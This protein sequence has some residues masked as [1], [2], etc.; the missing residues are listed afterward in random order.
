MNADL[1]SVL[2]D[3][4]NSSQSP[5]IVPHRHPDGDAL[6]SALAIF[7]SLQQA[8][9]APHVVVPTSIPKMLHWMPGVEQAIVAP[10]HPDIAQ[11]AIDKADLLVFVDFGDLRRLD[12]LVETVQQST[13]PIVLIDHHP[14]PKITAEYMW[15]DPHAPATALLIYRL[16]QKGQ[17]RISSTIAQ[18]LLTGIITDTGRFNYSLSPE[19]FTTTADLIA[20]G[21][22]LETIIQRIFYRFSENQLRFWGHT[23]SEQMEI[24]HP[25]PIALM[26]VSHKDFI[27]WK[28]TEDDLEGLVNFPLQ[29]KDIFISI[30]IRETPEEVKL[31]FRSRGPYPV[32]RWASEYFQ[33]GGHFHAA[34]AR[35][36]QPLKQ[37]IAQVK[38]SLPHFWKS[39]HDTAHHQT[40]NS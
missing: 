1:A 9:G 40:T 39:I 5:T 11:Q 27:Q 19:V 38:A 20:H 32:N 24:I 34:G 31:S 26:I 14:S 10:E 6:G 12:H 25:Y 4:L 35:S 36:F 17:R 13:A 21:A 16:F 3:A 30:L 37:V 7:H 33:G 28:I 22:D 15:W 8:Q 29:M 18:C 23:L 2:W